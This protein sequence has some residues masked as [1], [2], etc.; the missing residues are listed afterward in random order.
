[1]AEA[2]L[3]AGAG[4][5]DPSDQACRSWRRRAGRCAALF[6]A[7]LLVASAAPASADDLPGSV[8]VGTVIK[9]KDGDSLLVRLAGGPAG[10]D[11]IEI[12]LHGADAPESDQPGG[13]QAREFLR[14]RVVN[15][16]VEIEPV[17][18]DRYERMVAVVYRDGEN[19]SAALVTAGHAWAYRRYLAEVPG[20][21]DLCRLEDE[22]RRARRGLW[23]QPTNRWVPPWLHREIRR[24]PAGELRPRGYAAETGADCRKAIPR[25]ASAQRE[26]GTGKPSSPGKG[27][28][29]L[30][31]GNISAG[32]ERIYHL[33]GTNLYAKTR[34]KE[35][36]GERWFCTEA[37]A[38]AAGWRPAGQPQA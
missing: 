19:V 11:P 12:R 18:Q 26:A 38:R 28:N 9:A 15:R 3:P 5:P 6:I 21:D 25:Q 30:I 35:S 23:A 36:D 29:C 8:L 34:I 13:A 22:A 33:P 32:G 17:T 2:R 4:R 31:K 24:F 16:Q 37:E 1:M 7:T 27:R 20:A 10:A 14:R